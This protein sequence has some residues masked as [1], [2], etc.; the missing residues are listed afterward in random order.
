MLWVS[1]VGLVAIRKPDF[2]LKLNRRTYADKAGIIAINLFMKTAWNFN[3]NSSWIPETHL[4]DCANVRLRIGAACTIR[5]EHNGSNNKSAVFP[6]RKTGRLNFTEIFRYYSM[7]ASLL[8][9]NVTGLGNCAQNRATL[10][11]QFETVEFAF[12]TCNE[13][14]VTATISSKPELTPRRKRKQAETS[15][16]GTIQRI[17]IILP[18]LAARRGRVIIIYVL[19]KVFTYSHIIFHTHFRLVKLYFI[20]RCPQ[21]FPWAFIRCNEYVL[22]VRSRAAIER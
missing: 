5:Q 1:L 22:I 16:K 15:R 6:A 19:H 8:R 10:R 21:F 2:E 11:S 12:R 18:T 4:C 14:I 20:P 13:L 17:E 3:R 7:R 9:P